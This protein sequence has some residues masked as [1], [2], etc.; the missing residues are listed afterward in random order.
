MM[1]VDLVALLPLPPPKADFTLSLTPPSPPLSA[2]ATGLSPFAAALVPSLAALPRTPPFSAMSVNEVVAS[3]RRWVT[4][5]IAFSPSAFAASW[6]SS[7]SRSR[8]SSSISVLSPDVLPLSSAIGQP[9]SAVAARTARAAR[10]LGGGLLGRCLR[11]R[12]LLGGRLLGGRLAGGRLLGRGLLGRCL[13]GRCLLGRCLLGGR[14][15]GR[16]L[17]RRR[18]GGGR[19]LAGGLLRCRRARVGARR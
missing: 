17:L 14:L 5:P 4:L 9:Y 16:R 12:G 15:L 10:L 7:L 6:S 2:P 11:G 13:L 18:G 19:A 8:G 1:F 3:P